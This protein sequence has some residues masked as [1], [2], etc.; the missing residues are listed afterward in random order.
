MELQNKFA[1]VTGGARR[2]GKEIALALAR[3]G[4]HVAITYNTSAE[5][6]QTVVKQIKTL[7][8]RSIALKCD[9]TN[10]IE[11]QSLFENLER[12]FDHLDILINSAAIMER[13][14]VLDVTPADF[15]RTIETN[16]RGPFFIA[17]A[18]AKWM[19]RSGM[20]GS[21]VNIADLSAIQP[22][23]SYIA[24]TI[25]KSGLVAMTQA[26]AL[27]LAPSIRVNAIAPGTIL[28]PVDWDDNRWQKL[29]EAL[30]L[31]HGGSIEDVTQA[32]LFCLQNEFMTG[33]TLVIDGGRSLR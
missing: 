13:Q 30:P 17:Q 10:L 15:D 5:L 33:E 3:S 25:S 11:I 27:A 7:G 8:A 18:A 32:V 31:K 24:H 9:Q 6:A 4:A 26:L 1:L 2:L 16:L 22:W 12:E 29:I 23:P 19:K 20:A 14:P 28:K 21:I